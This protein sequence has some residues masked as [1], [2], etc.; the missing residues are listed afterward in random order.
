MLDELSDSNLNEQEN[1]FRKALIE[2]LPGVFY[3]IDMQGHFLMWNRNL[4]LVL[5]RSTD[6]IAA[7]HPLDFFKG[8][9]KGNIENAMRRVFEQG[10]AS[11][12]A[13][14]VAK[15]GSGS[16]YHFTGRRVERDGEPLLVGMGLDISKQRESMR[17]TTALLQRNQALM[18]NSMEGIHVMDVDGN[19]LEVNEAFCHMLGY[20]R[21]EVMR[22][23]VTDWDDQF[24]P[25][26][27]RAR[28]KGFIGK[29]GMFETVHRRKDG[30]LLDVEICTNGV[31]IDGKGYL[32]AASRDITERKKMQAV[33]Q[34][35]KRV[36]ETAM[37]GFWMTDEQGFLEEVNEA[38]AKMSGY[39]MQELV[40][41]HISQLEADEQAEDVQA[42]IEKIMALGYDRFETRHRRKDGRVVDIEVAATFMQETG[43]FFVF[44]HNISQ[45]KQ[46]EQELRVAA[47]AFETHEAILITDA[48]ANIIR[49]N[50]AFTEVT[51]FAAD[52]VIGKNPRIMSS[53]R[54][55]AAFY[56]AL[57]QQ[58]L[59]KGSW[60]GEIWDRR[61]NG[62]IYPKWMTI[63]AVKNE[64]GETMQYVAIFSDITE[65]KQA[66][67]EIRNLAF[68]DAL[69]QL[70]NRRLFLER[71]QTVLTAS[72]RHE[73][74]GALMYLDLDRFKTLN[75]TLGHDCGDQ[76]LVE[77]AARI[78][79]CVREIDM[80]A[81]L[82][83][84]EFVVL[85]ENISGDREE[86]SHK[87]GMVAEKVREA[88][89][90]PYYL[91]DRE[92]DSSPS[93][94][95]SLFHGSEEPMDELIKHADAAMY[96][97]KETGGNTVSFY[98]PEVHG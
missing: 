68:Y 54:H 30:S 22:L 58:I 89:A 79:S 96:Q 12:E 6:E 14:L 90:R 86:A 87:A 34:R 83:G 17:V 69:T 5:Q 2:S 23:N 81:R 59:E 25:E 31:E 66:E 85:L 78:K 71:F 74:F 16:P 61:K 40:G 88:L 47:A 20:T 72:A 46:S 62:E 37:D 1:A 48:Q 63:T 41:M 29:N 3:M 28:F 27:L 49:V 95:V 10:E 15:D 45:R 19:V 38:Y 36:I 42:R 84:D 21:E 97:S 44:S 98:A 64:R 24:S 4:E 32:F 9:D 52:E 33:Q 82:G 73:D 53:G 67:D 75:D 60:A 93:I 76:L 7:S 57:W 39:T 80:V 94:G 35:H 92:H 13:E 18:Q 11:V 65:R 50:R 56:A 77:V 26:E 70:P 51:G 55:D 8:G 43:K 91:K